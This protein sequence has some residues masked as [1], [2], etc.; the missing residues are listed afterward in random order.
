[1]AQADGL[2]FWSTKTATVGL[3][4]RD[5]V[6]VDCPPYARNWALNKD[7]RELWREGKRKGVDLQWLKADYLGVVE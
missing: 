5:G 2:I 4:V 1:M 7:A 3:L 6:V